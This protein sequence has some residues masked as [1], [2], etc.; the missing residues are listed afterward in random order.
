MK[1]TK[2]KD[3]FTIIGLGSLG[4][5][6]ILAIV[7][8]RLNKN[9]NVNELQKGYKFAFFLG[10]VLLGISQLFNEIKKENLSLSTTSRPPQACRTCESRVKQDKTED[11]WYNC[12]IINEDSCMYA[13]DKGDMNAC[14]NNYGLKTDIDIPTGLCKPNCCKYRVK[15]DTDDKTDNKW[16][17]CYNYD[18]VCKYKNDKG[19]DID[20]SNNYVLNS[21]ITTKLCNPK[22]IA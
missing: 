3:I 14:I 7:T 17:N 10:V 4:L 8:M 16:Y 21:E 22:A 9:C 11:K 2:I 13:N 20:C 19:V 5:C 1:K 15:Q 12:F 18:G 6:L